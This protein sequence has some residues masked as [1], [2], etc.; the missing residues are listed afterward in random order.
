MIERVTSLLELLGILA[1]T[2]ALGLLV[3]QLAGP[4]WALVAVGLT[5]FGWS[6]LVSFARRREVET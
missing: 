1:L 3:D 6:A 2:A 5:L 4:I